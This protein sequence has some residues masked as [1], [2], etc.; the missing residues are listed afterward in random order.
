MADRPGLSPTLTLRLIA[1]FLAVLIVWFGYWQV[2]ELLVRFGLPHWSL[3]VADT[4][5][6]VSGTSDVFDWLGR[7]LIGLQIVTL[8]LV[9]RRRR[10]ALWVLIASAAVHFV[11]WVWI[12]LDGWFAGGPGFFIIIGEAVSI[13]AL[14][15]L[16]A[17]GELR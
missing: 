9:L 15:R 3:P 8:V 7:I 10:A 12:T 1:A 5:A 14:M 11:N 17:I 2:G 16:R 6:Y 4:R 13:Y